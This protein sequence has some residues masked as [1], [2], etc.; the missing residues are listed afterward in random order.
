MILV[1]SGAYLAT[2]KLLFG[3]GTRQPET[4]VDVY[5]GI[6]EGHSFYRG[7]AL[8]AVGFALGAAAPRLAAWIIVLP[9]SGCPRCGYK[10]TIAP[11]APCPECGLAADDSTSPPQ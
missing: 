10:T 2:K 3:L 8:L 11:G 6:G 9:T 5:E 4:I 7:L 1:A